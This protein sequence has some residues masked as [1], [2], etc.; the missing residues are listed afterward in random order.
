MKRQ[1]IAKLTYLLFSS[2]S[3]QAKAL[4]PQSQL[5][6]AG[7]GDRGVGK[8]IPNIFETAI[9][10]FVEARVKPRSGNSQGGIFRDD[11]NG[12]DTARFT[13][14][15]DL[16]LR[17]QVNCIAVALFDCLSGFRGMFSSLKVG[18]YLLFVLHF[19]LI[20]HH[21]SN[22]HFNAAARQRG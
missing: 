16:G 8:R 17:H 1:T 2:K 15:L 9:N 20:R 18:H 19:N 11:G 14:M 7:T 12:Q 13:G 21:Q 5:R 4:K 6:Y 3:R 22:R 10:G